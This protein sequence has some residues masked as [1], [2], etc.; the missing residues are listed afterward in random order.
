MGHT[1]LRWDPSDPKDP[2][3]LIDIV[4]MNPP[5]VIEAGRLL[6]LEYPEARRLKALIDTGASITII[7]KT[8]ATYCKLFT[9]SEG[10]EVRTLG[11]SYR[12][13]EHAASISFP[14]TDLHS[15]SSICVYSGDFIKEPRYACLV[16]RDILRNWEITFD[17]RAK[18]IT[19]AD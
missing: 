7:S 1:E 6:G 11:G 3:P 18:R 2:G 5:E 8:F 19:I 10:S 14:N 15:I 4:I 9:T 12:C 13:G 17:G 16:G